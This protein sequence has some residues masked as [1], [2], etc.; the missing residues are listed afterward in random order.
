MQVGDYTLE[1]SEVDI[2]TGFRSKTTVSYSV[3]AP[4][5]VFDPSEFFDLNE[6]QAESDPTE[7]GVSGE[8]ESEQESGED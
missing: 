1:V 7:E 5:N 8:T 3:E 2:N 4:P 6:T